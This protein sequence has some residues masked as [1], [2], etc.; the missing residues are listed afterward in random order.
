MREY[1]ERVRPRLCTSERAEEGMHHLL[2]T[3]RA[4]GSGWSYY[5]GSRLLSL[6]SVAITPR[7][8]RALGN[9]DRPGIVDLAIKLPARIIVWLATLFGSFGLIKGAPLIAPMAGRIL[10]QHLAMEEP[11]E[12]VTITPAAA[13]ARYGLHGAQAS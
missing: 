8:M 4:N 9:Y 11:A 12:P 7:W 3:S 1:F 13:R 2:W 10:A 6:A 5:L